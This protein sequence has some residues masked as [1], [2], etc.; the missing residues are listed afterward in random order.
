MENIN[1]VAVKL[2]MKS[3]KPP[4]RKTPSKKIN[5]LAYLLNSKSIKRNSF[6]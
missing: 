1:L 5:G 2:S 3:Q 4:V 6:I